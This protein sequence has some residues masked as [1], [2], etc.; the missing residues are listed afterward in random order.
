MIFMVVLLYNYIYTTWLAVVLSL[1]IVPQII[2]SA[3]RG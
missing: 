1:Y 2:H 3:L